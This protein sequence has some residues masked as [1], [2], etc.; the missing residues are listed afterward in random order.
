M[1]DDHNP[2][3]RSLTPE[4]YVKNLSQYRKQVNQTVGGSGETCKMTGHDDLP[5]CCCQFPYKIL[6]FQQVKP[7]VA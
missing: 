5:A 3:F 6:E 4:T 7:M 2:A 1:T